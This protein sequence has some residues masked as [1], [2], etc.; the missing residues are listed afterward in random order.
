MPSKR[1]HTAYVFTI[2]L[3]GFRGMGNGTEMM[4]RAVHIAREK[5]VE[6][7]HLSVF[8]SNTRAIDFYRRLGFETEAVLRKQFIMDGKYVDEVHMARWLD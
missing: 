4:R 7:L 2:V 1:S 5:G 8:S 3:K 6:K